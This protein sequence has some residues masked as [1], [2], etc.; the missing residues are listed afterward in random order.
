MA[1]RYQRCNQNP[2]IEQGQTTQWPKANLKKD[3]ERIKEEYINVT[4]TTQQKSI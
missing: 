2:Y 1:T 3:K 4:A